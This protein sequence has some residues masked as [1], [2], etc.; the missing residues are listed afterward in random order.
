ME[1][2][3]GWK[4]KYL[5]QAGREILIKATAQAIP[6]YVMSCFKIPIGCCLKTEQIIRNFW[7]GSDDG[8]KKIYWVAWDT[9]CKAKQ[10]GELG[11]RKL[12]DL[13][14]A[15]LG[16]QVWR[17]LTQ[18]NC[19]MART[20]KARYYPRVEILSANIGFHLSF[21]WR[22]IWGA[23]LMVEEGIRWRISAGTEV[24]IWG[25]RWLPDQNGGRV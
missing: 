14:D 22:S 6:N 4:G 16:K 9:C 20:L 7:W 1:K 21:I 5:T 15:L 24:N 23:R 19:L 8:I 17:L 2:I 13:N 12:E 10:V 11:F 25:S 3:K 18:Q